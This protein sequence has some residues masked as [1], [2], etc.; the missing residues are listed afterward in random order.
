LQLPGFLRDGRNHDRLGK[1]LPFNELRYGKPRDG[2]RDSCYIQVEEG[3]FYADFIEEKG[4]CLV[5][6]KLWDT[7]KAKQLVQD[8]DVYLSIG[9]VSENG[10]R[11]GELFFALQRKKY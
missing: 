3:S 7:L 10:R 5:S 2:N 6:L 1:I 8:E 4:L 9:L 11:I